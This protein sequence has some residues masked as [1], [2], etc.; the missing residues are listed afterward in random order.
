MDEIDRIFTA[1]P[2]YGKRRMT[3]TLRQMGKDIGVKH[4]R[5]LM[6]KMGLEAIYP[7]KRTSIPNPSHRVYPY[8]LR[9][10]EI[11]RP[12]QVW[13][14]DITYIRLLGG[15]V[16]LTAI[17]DWHSRYVLSWK[18]SVTMEKEFCMEALE[19]ALKIN[20]PEIFN[21][22]QGSQ[23]TSPEFTGLL[24]GRQVKI[25]MDG[26]GR[27]MDNIFTERLW[28]T[29]KYEEVYLKNYATPLEAR[30]GLEGYFRFYNNIR[31][32]Q[33][34]DYRTPAQVYFQSIA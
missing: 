34:L 16:Y 7:K 8:L 26:K 27:C 15:F 18:L 17:M 10:V 33:S 9:D 30:R 31:P 14:T 23:F 11:I 28:R 3:V 12:D 29:V 5:T 25:S 2:F 1:H 4:T 24:E 22:D 6:L 21:S 13:A 32:H 20:L 19:E